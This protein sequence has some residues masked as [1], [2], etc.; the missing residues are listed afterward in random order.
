MFNRGP[1]NYQF[2]DNCH[3]FTLLNKCVTLPS[4]TLPRGGCKTRG[5][6]HVKSKP[7]GGSKRKF[8]FQEGGWYQALVGIYFLVGKLSH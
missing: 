6:H 2:L 3:V 4:L 7:K 5:E 1:Q 8:F